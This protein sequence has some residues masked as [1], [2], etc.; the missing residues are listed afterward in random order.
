MNHIYFKTRHLFVLLG[1]FVC[2]VGMA[3][4]PFPNKLKGN[5]ITALGSPV[6]SQT[7][8]QVAKKTS[9]PNSGQNSDPNN[10]FTPKEEKIKGKELSAAE[11]ELVL[12]Q[13]QQSQN[14]SGQNLTNNISKTNAQDSVKTN[15]KSFAKSSNLTVK[16]VFEVKK[17][18]F[19][20]TSS[21]RMQLK[22]VSDKHGRSL[23]TYQQLHNSIPVEGAIYKVRENK[24]KIDAFGSVSKK[25]PA[26]SN[27]KI[28]AAAAL[29]NALRTIN[30]K[31]Y[32]WESKKLSSLVHE[33][34]SKKPQG[35]LV[36]VGPNS[37]CGFLLIFS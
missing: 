9:D 25:L 6:T 1:F 4:S 17:E 7:K 26:A 31:Q 20:L 2:S 33:K 18:S 10:L 32:V 30:A 36:Y 29:E 19:G 12:K 27:Y 5:A 15:V 23:A 21:D 34:I 24:T 37:P 8:A 22:S 28:N 14:L 11:S 16:N 35:E 3:Q 13:E